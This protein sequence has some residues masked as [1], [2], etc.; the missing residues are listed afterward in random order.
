VSLEA[1]KL[2]KTNERVADIAASV[3]IRD[4]LYFNK[5]FHKMYRTSPGA[6]RAAGS[7]T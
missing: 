5:L 2:K 3:G 7:G 4:P 6:Y 1:E